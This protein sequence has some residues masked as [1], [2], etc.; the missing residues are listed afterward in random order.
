MVQFDTEH[1]GR[2]CCAHRG[3]S[4]HVSPH[5]EDCPIQSSWEFDEPGHN[6]PAS[7]TCPIG[8]Q[9]WTFR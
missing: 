4:Y 1:G 5:S 8:C 3:C 2:H 9:G 6:H 7:Q